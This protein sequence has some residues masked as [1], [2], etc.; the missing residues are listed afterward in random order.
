ML[1]LTIA[2]LISVQAN[3]ILNGGMEQEGAKR[4]L[5]S[6]RKLGDCPEAINT[7]KSALKDGDGS[8]SDVCNTAKDISKALKDGTTEAEADAYCT[9]NLDSWK[10]TCTSVC[11]QYD[12]VAAA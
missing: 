8:W 9:A 1:S 11:T 2:T 4:S 5:L 3:V 12:S 7:I 10:S 6:L